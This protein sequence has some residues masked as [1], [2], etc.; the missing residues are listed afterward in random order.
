MLL[1]FR[2]NY[3]MALSKNLRLIGGLDP[4]KGSRVG[5]GNIRPAKTP[6]L[7]FKKHILPEFGPRDTNKSPMWPADENSCPPLV[8]GS[9]YTS[10]KGIK[11]FAS[12]HFSGPWSLF[13][14]LGVHG[15]KRVKNHCSRAN[16][17]E[18][19]LKKCIYYLQIRVSHSIR[20]IIRV[21]DAYNKNIRDLTSIK[22]S[23]K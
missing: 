2:L 3:S 20:V 17:V 16:T 6:F 12:V 11:W 8:Q 5:R 7:A 22:I 9:L 21:S 23:P 13:L 19:R 4:W 18:V 10:F 15:A 1:Q 14:L